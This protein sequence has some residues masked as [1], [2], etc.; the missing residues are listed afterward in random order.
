MLTVAELN[1]IRSRV[2]QHLSVRKNESEVKVVIASGTTAIAAGS[3]QL[4]SAALEE[5]AKSNASSIHIEQRELDVEASEQPAVLVIVN[6][7][8]TLHKRCTVEM[9]RDLIRTNAPANSEVADN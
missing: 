8:E 9:I 1:E 5:I 6:E 2:R 4:M 7:Q 3:R